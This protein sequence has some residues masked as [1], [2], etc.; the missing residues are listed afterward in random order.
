MRILFVHERFGALGGAEANAVITAEELQRKGHEIGILHG[1]RTGKNEDRW[2]KVFGW[3]RQLGN[4]SNRAFF[5]ADALRAFEPDVIYV[6]KMADLDVIETLVRSGYPTVRMVHDHDV[7]CMRGY[8]YNPFSRR[9]C[10]R[11]GRSGSSRG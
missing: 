7:Y 2:E 10:T 6:H 5:V 4:A 11:P 9:I 3:R 8:K 1:P